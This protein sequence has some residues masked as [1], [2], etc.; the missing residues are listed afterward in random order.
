[1]Y[2]I[3][4]LPV[5]AKEKKLHHKGHKDHKGRRIK[6]EAEKGVPFFSVVSPALRFFQLLLFFFTL[7][8]LCVLCG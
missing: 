2:A 8:A 6:E 1:L 3:G 5:L 7:R 4:R